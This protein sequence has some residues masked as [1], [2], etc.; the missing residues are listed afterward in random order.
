MAEVVDKLKDDAQKVAPHLRHH[1]HLHLHLPPEPRRRHAPATPSHRG[2][3]AALQE[4]FVE[5]G[6]QYVHA[7]CDELLRS[8]LVPGLHFYALNSEARTFELLKRLG[9]LRPS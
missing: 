2:A 3:P 9:F 6:L 4:D 1:L 5:F 8:K 7:L